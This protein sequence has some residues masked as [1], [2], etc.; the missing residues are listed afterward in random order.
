MGAATIEKGEAMEKA[1]RRKRIWNCG[2]RRGTALVLALALAGGG[3]AAGRTAWACYSGLL[4]IPTADMVPAENVSAELQIDG[5]IRG[6]AD[7]TRLLNTELGITDR[8]ELGLDLQNDGDDS[9][10]RVYP[11]LNGKLLIL[12]GGEKSPALAAG[13]YA[14]DASDPV[15][16]VPYLALTQDFK[17]FRAHFGVE[18]IEDHYRPFIG[19]DRDLTEK[20]TF[21]ADYTYGPENFASLGG[22]YQLNDHFGVMAGL[23]FPNSGDDLR[24]TVHLVLCGSLEDL[25]R[26]ADGSGAKSEPGKEK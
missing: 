9:P 14:I 20:I 24:F 19:L 22:N 1:E 18:K 2:R 8:L 5:V 21:M 15:A 17:F 13:I 10:E 26:K 4:N 6:L 23:M 25:D 11:V 16:N 12:K 3:M 7:D